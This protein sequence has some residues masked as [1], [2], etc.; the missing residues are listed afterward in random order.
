ML[1]SFLQFYFI[2]VSC[3][4]F[5]AC[6]KNESTKVQPSTIPLE[7]THKQDRDVDSSNGDVK[8]FLKYTDDNDGS[9]SQIEIEDPV[10]AEHFK[11]STEMEQR[12][13]ISELVTHSVKRIDLDKMMKK[14][15]SE[16]SSSGESFDSGLQDYID[17]LADSVTDV[18]PFYVN[19]PTE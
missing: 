11:S 12:K 8:F 13:I 6:S 10:L 17:S 3:I 19:P 1:K 16:M 5:F 2:S 14:V 15:K 9:T 7:T 4:L 18:E